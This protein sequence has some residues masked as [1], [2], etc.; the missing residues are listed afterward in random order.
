MYDKNFTQQPHSEYKHPCWH[1]TLGAFMLLLVS[2]IIWSQASVHRPIVQLYTYV[3][4]AML[5]KPGHQLQIHPH[6]A[7]L[8]STPTILQSYIQVSAIVWECR[9]G[10]TDTH[11]DTQ[12]AGHNTFR[13][14][15]TTAEC[16]E[17]N[18]RSTTVGMLTVL[19]STTQTCS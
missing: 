4:V 6:S 12:T 3:Y 9:E 8:G 13:L 7:Q 14:A 2:F 15:I 1:F 16:N 19:Y 10:Q 18:A 17:R 5:T 11:A